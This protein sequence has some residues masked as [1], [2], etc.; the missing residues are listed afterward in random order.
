LTKGGKKMLGE[1]IGTF[2]VIFTLIHLVIG[3]VIMDLISKFERE[4]L[5]LTDT[6]IIISWPIYL[7]LWHFIF[8]DKDEG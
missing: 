8:F 2:I 5:D 4:P 6:H 7:P 3:V 1:A